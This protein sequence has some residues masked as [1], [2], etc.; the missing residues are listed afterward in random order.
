MLLQRANGTDRRTDGWTPY[1]Y[2][3]PA[4][5]IMRTVPIKWDI[6]GNSA[7]GV[8]KNLMVQM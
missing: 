6:F 8:C 4:L 2:I 1:R 7:H 3:D 5:H